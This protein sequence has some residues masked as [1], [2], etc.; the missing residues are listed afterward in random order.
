MNELALYDQRG[1][2]L[3]LAEAALSLDPS[4]RVGAIVATETIYRGHNHFL[5]AGFEP[6]SASREE[7]Y[8]RVVHAE[9]AAL[10]AA[11][12]FARGATVYS[13]EEPCLECAKALVVAGVRRVVHMAT[14][15]DRRE[16]WQCDLGRR[17][18]E[19]ASV[20]LLEV[21]R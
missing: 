18:L 1:L 4:T 6:G 9:L 19:E 14:T 10:L 12:S 11:G 3:A 15:P 7:R 16:R 20:E 13:S 21:P 8:A 5:G 17:L 2:T